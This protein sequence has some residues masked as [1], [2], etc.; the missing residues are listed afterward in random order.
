MRLVGYSNR[1]SVAPGESIAFMVSSAHPTYDAE[2]VR[3]VHGDP[4]S[5]GPGIIE[6]VVDTPVNGRYE[7][8]IQSIHT[9]SNITVK[10]GPSLR[11]TGSFTIQA[12]IF[13]T[14]PGKEVQGLVTKWSH[15]APAGCALVISDGALALWLAD[16]TGRVARVGAGARLQARTWYFIAA[17]FDAGTGEV[18]LVQEPCQDWPHDA[19][20]RVVTIQTKLRAV[21]PGQSALLVGALP[22]DRP[23]QGRGHYNGKI[24]RPSLFNRA[25]SDAELDA[26]KL[27][28][29][30]LDLG[31]ALAAA[32][33]FSREISSDRIID[34]SPNSNHGTAV[35]LPARAMTGAN[36]TGDESNF[37]RAPGEYGA[38]HFHDDDLDDAGWETD[39]TFT[40]PDSLPSGIYAARLR[41]GSNV[42]RLPFVVRPPRGVATSRIAYLI[43]TFTYLAYANEHMPVEPLSLFPFADMDAQRA[44]YEYIS[45]NHLNSM[46]DT[47]N[48]GT[49]VC[50]ASWKRPLVNIRPDAIFRIYG[51]TE[52][53]SADLYLTHWLEQKEFAYD[54][55]ADENLHSEGEA[56]LSPYRVVVT[57][58][59]PEYWTKPMLDALNRYLDAGGRVMY[60]GGNG[61]YWVTGVDPERPH[62]IEIRRWRGTETWEADPGEFFLSTTGEQGGLWRHRNRAP[63]KRLGVG[64]TAQGNDV[65]RPYVRQPDSYTPEAAFIFEGVTEDVIGDFQSL[66]LRHG[67]AGYEIDRADVA[68]GTPS[69]A[70]ILAS[71]TGF[72]DSYQHV[73][74][75]ILST[76]NERGGTTNPLVRADIVYCEDPHGGA[77]FSVGSIAWCSALSYRDGHNDVSRIT[78][79]VLRHFVADDR[80]P[81]GSA[82]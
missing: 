27:G 47:H 9:G 46:Y 77:V 17:T 43:P 32:W 30:P 62:V 56:L 34:V 16:G 18:R 1:L 5:L 82:T 57:G 10:E 41:A 81:G 11:I 54:T 19:S 69:Q 50:Y 29:S 20:S 58:T 61:F 76:D 55:I 79:N 59:H 67:A 7:G 24:E 28:G 14:T 48:D 73:V 72:S 71:A 35:N 22:G 63:Q 36:W 25:L 2:I 31:E 42:D 70:L 37:T 3:L 78:E 38:I 49:G 80:L 6:Q 33:D 13:P 4:N 26:L 45:E 15:A 75:E 12:W 64:F 39:F 8:R 60:L 65:A 52:R 40:I 74:E 53:L 21:E 51:G 23:G 68:L 66:M 44:E